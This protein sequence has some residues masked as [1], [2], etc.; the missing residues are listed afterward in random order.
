MKKA[1]IISLLIVISLFACKKDEDDTPIKTFSAPAGSVY[2]SNEGNF[3]S[4]NASVSYYYPP[5]RDVVEN[6]YKS[7][8]DLDLGDICQSMYQINDKMYIV[9][10]NSGKIEVV[11]LYSMQKAATITNLNSPRYVVK[12]TSAK[13]YISSLYDNAISVLDL[14]TNAVISRIDM[15]A[16]S[17][18]M[19][20]YQN[21]VYVTNLN[22]DYLY[23]INT[24]TDVITDSVFTG[25]GEN[26]IVLDADNKIWVL[27]SGD[28]TIPTPGNLVRFDP[29]TLTIDLVLPFTTSDFPN[30][31]CINAQRNKLY[32]LNTDVYSM[33][34]TSGALPSS[35]F[36]SSGGRNLY[37]LGIHP[38]SA[39]VYVSDAI[40]FSQKGRIYR[41]NSSGGS[42]DNF[43]AG[44]IPGDFSFVE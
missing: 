39:E 24:T 36:I 28:Y 13:A 9:V 16:G 6:I 26:S 25:K 14:N 11:N 12:A 4:G 38:T 43:T 34:I 8:N 1:K 35:A 33:D 17:E 15:P 7:V 21:K 23:I 18:Q 32:F 19:L 5:S 27:T 41:Y 31:L 37:G 44:I 10:N 29:A 3:Q 42:I 2:I 20:F 30:R 22:S 40:D